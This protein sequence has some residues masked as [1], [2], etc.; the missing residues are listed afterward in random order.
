VPLALLGG[1]VLHLPIYWV[2][3]MV[4]AEEVVK[5]LVGLPRVF[6]KKWIHYLAQ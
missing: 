1:F 5:L 2:V 3:L 4:Q 6:S